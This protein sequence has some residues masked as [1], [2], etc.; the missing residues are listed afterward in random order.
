MHLQA[1]LR[2]ACVA[3]HFWSLPTT[4]TTLTCWISTMTSIALPSWI[5]R[6]PMRPKCCQVGG[7]TR[8][9]RRNRARPD[10]AA[11]AAA[12]DA[13]AVAAAPD[14]AAVA[15]ARH[16]A[17]HQNHRHPH[18]HPDQYQRHPHPDQHQHHQDL[19]PV[20]QTWLPCWTD[21]TSIGACMAY[22]FSSGT[23]RSKGLQKNGD[24]K[25]VA[26]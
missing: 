3:G 12:P 26:R 2:G 19:A 5:C 16:P 23:S 14:A 24:G 17:Q 13:A 22:L 20:M 10:A 11:V 9:S 6:R 7:V 4:S 1:M 18:Q 25:P 8:R 21:T 15:A